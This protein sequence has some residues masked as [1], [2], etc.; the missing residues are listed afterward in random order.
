MV[1]DLLPAARE[2]LSDARAALV[3]GS[4]TGSVYLA[5][6]VVEIVLKHATFRAQG[7]GPHDLV[8]PALAPVRARLNHWLGPVPYESYHSLDFWALALRETVRN[9]RGALHDRLIQAVRRAQL[10]HKAWLVAL[11]YQSSLLPARDAE[12]FLGAA[13]WFSKNALSIGR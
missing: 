10:L 5:G 11:R 12:E 13:G 3:H 2:R 6:F 7:L 4:P 1:Q 8:Q 9:R